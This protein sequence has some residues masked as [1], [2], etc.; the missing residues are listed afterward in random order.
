[1]THK[2]ENDHSTVGHYINFVSEIK[3]KRS[4]LHDQ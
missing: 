4:I 1:M 3:N 2:I